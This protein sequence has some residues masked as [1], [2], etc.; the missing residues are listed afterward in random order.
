MR[1]MLNNYDLINEGLNET[2]ISNEE[3]KATNLLDILNDRT[4][5]WKGAEKLPTESQSE[6]RWNR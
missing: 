1:P 6:A 2:L 4:I 3:V 5:G